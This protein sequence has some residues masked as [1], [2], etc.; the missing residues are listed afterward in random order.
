VSTSTVCCLHVFVPQYG[1]LAAIL[2]L[3]ALYHCACLRNA[4]RT[5][6]GIVRILVY[7]HQRIKQHSNLQQFAIPLLP[8]FIPY[9]H[10]RMCVRG[11]VNDDG[12]QVRLKI[13]VRSLLHRKIQCQPTTACCCHVFVPQYG[14]LAAIFHL[15]AFN[16]C[17]CLRN[18][19][20]ISKN[21]R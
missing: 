7:L 13:G 16:H 14:R 6:Y 20:R 9:L 3:L 21:H 18:A 19:R 17:A 2:S 4:R 1:H 10:H 12:Y 15:L 8:S 11:E 5:S